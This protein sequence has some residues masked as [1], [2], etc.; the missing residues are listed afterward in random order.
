MRLE[1]ITQVHILSKY[2]SYIQARSDWDRQMKLSSCNPCIL[3]Q[4]LHFWKQNVRKLNNKKLHYNISLPQAVAYWESCNV[5]NGSYK[6]GS[7]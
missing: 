2:P 1:D 7:G 3:V 5:T 4:E 6:Y